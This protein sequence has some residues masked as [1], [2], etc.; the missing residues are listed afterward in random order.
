MKNNKQNVNKI[1][2]PFTPG[3]GHEMP[4]LRTGNGYLHYDS[5]LCFAFFH[6]I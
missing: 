3:D 1:G 5:K 6:Y 4:A 2:D